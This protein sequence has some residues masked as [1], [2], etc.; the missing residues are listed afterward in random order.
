MQGQFNYLAFVFIVPKFVKLSEI[1][2]TRLKIVLNETLSTNFNEILPNNV[3]SNPC[4]LNALKFFLK[5]LPFTS[6]QLTL[7][8]N[9]EVCIVDR[10]TCK[11]VLMPKPNCRFEC[12]LCK[13]FSSQRKTRGTKIQSRSVRQL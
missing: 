10:K 1:Q 12:V 4:T 5:L 13:K 7:I 11:L 3:V 8:I 6:G 2:K 9:N